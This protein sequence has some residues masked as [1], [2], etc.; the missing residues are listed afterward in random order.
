[1]ACST[2]CKLPAP[3]LQERG[4]KRVNSLAKPSTNDQWYF[5]SLLRRLFTLHRCEVQFYHLPGDL[6]VDFK[7]ALRLIW[8]IILNI[9]QF[10]SLFVPLVCV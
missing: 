5:F 6:S 10:L 7:L 1:M 3:S 2:R 4:R 8:G 9:A